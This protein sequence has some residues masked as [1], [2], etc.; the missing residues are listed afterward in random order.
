[1]RPLVLFMLLSAIAATGLL[2]DHFRP[3]TGPQV[4]VRV[5]MDGMLIEARI[6][7]GLPA[8]SVTRGEGTV[9]SLGSLIR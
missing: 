8:L 4:A 1:M 2:L 7:V 9:L 5:E 3:A 6:G